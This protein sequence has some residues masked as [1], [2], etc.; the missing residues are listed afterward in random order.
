VSQQQDAVTPP[1]FPREFL[2]T[3][4]SVVLAAGAHSGEALEHL[5]RSY[6]Y[7]VYG[8]IRRRGVDEHRAKDLTQDFFATLLS[9]DGLERVTPERGKFRAFILAAVKN[10]LTNDWRDANR[11]KRGGGREILS[12]EA[13]DAEERYRN[14]SSDAPAEALFDIAWAQSVVSTALRRLEEEMERD[15]VRNRYEVLKGFLQGD[16]KGLT[17]DEAA[18]RLDFSLSAVKSA[19]LRMR[20]RYGELIRMEVAATVGPHENVEDEIQLLISVLSA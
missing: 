17:Y 7:P 9:G 15:G 4:W 11:R 10:S 19:I 20:R 13:L 8:F 3:H 6:W 1:E 2:T 18:A 16:G 14:E 12:W 5:C